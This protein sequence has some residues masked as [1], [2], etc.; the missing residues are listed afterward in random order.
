[1]PK[2]EL[3]ISNIEQICL[4]LDKRYPISYPR[5][6]NIL[7]RTE[8]QLNTGGKNLFVVGSR[9][10]INGIRTTYAD[11]FSTDP[12]IRSDFC[13][14]LQR[15]YFS[16]ISFTNSMRFFE[17]YPP[18]FVCIKWS[19]WLATSTAIMR[20]TFINSVVGN[21]KFSKGSTFQDVFNRNLFFRGVVITLDT[22]TRELSNQAQLF[23][24]SPGQA[25]VLDWNETTPS[26]QSGA[27]LPSQLFTGD[28]LLPGKV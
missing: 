6:S 27:P 25:I 7:K 16:L 13:V 14:T 10:A 9:Q 17:A 28:N 22:I 3:A 26:F 12:T 8:N 23:P 1:M 15:R 21:P 4:G 24:G 11:L 5:I 2:D 20:R 19:D 18:A